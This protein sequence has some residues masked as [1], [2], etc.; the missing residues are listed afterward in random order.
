[1]KNAIFFY[2]IGQV[3]PDGCVR[4]EIRSLTVHCLHKERGCDWEDKITSLEVSH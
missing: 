1:M 4:K 2:L 3:F